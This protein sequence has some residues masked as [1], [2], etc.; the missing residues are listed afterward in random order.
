VLSKAQLFSGSP[1]TYT[2]FTRMLNANGSSAFTVKPVRSLSSS[3]SEYLLN[4]SPGGGNFVTLWR[5]DNAPT[6]PVMNRVAAVTVGNYAVPVNAAQHGTRNLINTG[7]CRTQ[8]LIWQNGLLYTGIS[9]RLGTNK[10]NYIDAVRYLQINTSTGTAVKDISYTASG[11]F[12]YYPAVT[13]DASGNM[14]MTF[15]RSSSNEYASM[16]ATGMLTT[17]PAIESSALVKSGVSSNTSGR[18]GDYSGVAND[19]SDGSAVWMY[20][21][22]ANTSNRWATWNSASSFGVPPSSPDI[23]SNKDNKSFAL[24]G[25]FPN[26]FNPTTTIYFTISEPSFVSIKIYNIL[27]QVVGSLV[28]EQL[29][30]GNHITQVNGENMASGV[31][32][33]KLTAGKNT[34]VGKMLLLK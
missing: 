30:A 27:G 13:V 21:G 3:S 14:L 32:Y 22:W 23:A 11:I 9:E 10:K 34:A 7:D 8:D 2:D 33:Y 4:T 19:P 17:D 29:N 15:S 25:N 24:H 28:N 16:Y 20:C 26:P 12:L 18:W 31:Y 6:S 1:A 5:I